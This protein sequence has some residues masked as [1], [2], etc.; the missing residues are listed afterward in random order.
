MTAGFARPDPP[1]EPRVRIRTRQAY[2]RLWYG[3]S[4]FGHLVVALAL[5]VPLGSWVAIGAALGIASLVAWRM[6]AIVADPPR[7]RP[8]VVLVDQ[9]LFCHLAAGL[10]G[11]LF[12]P[13]TLAATLAL[14]E[15]AWIENLSIA[16]AASYGG[17]L[18]VALWAITIGRR[19]VRCRTVRV[20]VVDLPVRFDGY[21]I[22]Q[23]SDLHIGSYDRPR[24]ARRWARQAMTLSPD[25]LVVTGDLVT[26]GTRHYT[27]VAEVLGGVAP[28]DGV[29]VVSGNHDQWN[30]AAL[31]EQ[32]HRVGARLLDG[33]SIS[34]ERG[35][36]RIVV[37]GIEG[38]HDVGAA[39]DRSLGA[40]SQSPTVLLAHYPE[41]FE[42]AAAHGVGLTL[43]GHTH[44]GQFAVP[45]LERWLNL[46]TLTGHRTEGLYCRGSCWLY[47]SAGL[48]ATGLPMRFGARP[49][50]TRI[51]LCRAGA[52]SSGPFVRS[53]RL[54]PIEK[55]SN[56]T[57]RSAGAKMVRPWTFGVW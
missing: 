34:I 54:R 49:E 24:H 20:P 11:L 22:A 48:G 23:L 32:L 29:L 57:E 33:R 45:G 6:H 3:A 55:R 8:I 4:A 14:P 47:V 41:A 10:V 26:S 53:D 52:S 39:M 5:L 2:V 27:A 19:R 9:P 44:A 25:L 28:P 18:L 51:V 46:A 17:G 50:I 36:E 1:G 56:E 38:S 30:T 35:S 43:S 16:S 37:A 13:A 42:R 40:L 15:L 21:V 31:E 7:P 12:L